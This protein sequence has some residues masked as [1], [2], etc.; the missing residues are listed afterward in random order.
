M[1]EN[2]EKSQK[3]KNQETAR[4]QWDTWIIDLEEQEQPDVCTTD[5]DECEACGS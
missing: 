3:D 1:I 5:D 2:E 4:K